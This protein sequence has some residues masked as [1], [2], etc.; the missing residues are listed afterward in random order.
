M[1]KIHLKNIVDVLAITLLIFLVDFATKANALQ[2]LREPLIIIPNFLKFTLQYNTGVAFS[3]GVPYILQIVATP[4]LLIL[5]FYFVVQNFDISKWQIYTLTGAIIGGAIG[6]FV[7]RIVYGHVVDFISVGQFP[8]FNIA[9]I[10][11]TLSIF[12]FI[13]FYVKITRNS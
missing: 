1:K 2:Y 3:I 9:D 8:V 12:I 10:A 4:I 13:L 11:I 5:G 6:N 7:D